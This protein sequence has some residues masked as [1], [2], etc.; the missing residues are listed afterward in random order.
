MVCC[1]F[2]L[3]SAHKQQRKALAIRLIAYYLGG[4][5]KP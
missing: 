2:G 3:F 4:S 5:G 1:I